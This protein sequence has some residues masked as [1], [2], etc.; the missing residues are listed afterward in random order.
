MG[1]IAAT[2][3]GS[4]R[5]RRLLLPYYYLTTYPSQLLPYYYLTQETTGVDIE[6]VF[7]RFPH[8]VKIMLQEP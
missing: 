4:S 8:G 1:G 2:S 5:P 7:R 3:D 6:S